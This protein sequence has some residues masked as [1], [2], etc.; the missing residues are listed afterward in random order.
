MKKIAITGNIASGKSQVEKELI[1]LGYKVIDTDKINHEI[2][3]K[4]EKT[5]QEIKNSFIS[6]DILNDEERLSREKLGKIIFS[7]S[8][9]KKILENILH[10]KIYEKLEIFY[11][12]N[13]NEKL[14]FVSIP[15]LF[16]AKQENKFD[17][18]V[19]VSAEEEI[20]LKRLIERN[21]YN[22]DYAKTRIAAQE[23]EETKIAKSDFIIYNNSDLTNLRMQIEQV[24]QQLI[25][26]C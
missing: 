4:D 17:K 23:K 19:F 18:I 12:N 6:C 22:I 21:K 11:E 25:L 1:L 5:I 15:L 14:V 10:E 8:E 24:L 9:K 20:R 26:S 13:K 2:L 3:E 16:E 7:D